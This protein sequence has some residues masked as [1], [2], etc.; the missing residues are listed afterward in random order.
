MAT[1]SG[2]CWLTF[3]LGRRVGRSLRSHS[4]TQDELTSLPGRVELIVRA[5][6]AIAEACKSGPG[7]ALAVLNLNRL[8]SVND[9]LGH[10]AGDELL[11]QLARRV[12]AALRPGDV[13]GRLAGDEFLVLLHEVEEASQ[14]Q[15]LLAKVQACVAEPFAISSRDIHA[16]LCI[17]VSICPAHGA[18]FDLLLRRAQTA[19]RYAKEAG[20][21]APVLYATHMCSVEEG[22]LA[23][24]EDL[25]QALERGQLELHYQ[26]KV[27]ISTGRVRSAEALIRWCHPKRG[28]VPPDVFIPL[29]EETGLI[30][31][32]GE[33]VLRTACWQLRAWLNEG[34]SPIRVAVNVS[35]RQFQQADLVAVVASALENA[36]L[37]PG[38]LELELT[39][40][41]VMHDPEQ[42]ASVLERLSAMG[43]HI[44]IDDFGTGYSSLSYLR[45]FPLDKLKIDRSFVRDLMSDKDD[46]AIVRAIISLAHSLRLKVVAEGVESSEQL[47]F[48]REMGCD[49]YQ[50]FHC[51]AAVPAHEFAALIERLR[52]QTPTLSS[53]ADMLRTQSRLSAF[54]RA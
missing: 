5:E 6:R 46:V 34:M 33:W 16:S 44:S 24:E 4:P 38:F 10:A 20:D 9:S 7:C 41:S 35:P 2:L 52:A 1:A 25:R 50:G 21:T 31:P 15:A 3:V 42:S 23:L 53:E 32:I 14:A 36:R 13:V 8:K 43:V 40:S 12:Q 39:E 37:E 18:T 11:R 51:S 19:M 45:R 17:G 29:A 49:Q 27:D 28:S 30:L 47:A 22:R 54:T 26:P 48:L